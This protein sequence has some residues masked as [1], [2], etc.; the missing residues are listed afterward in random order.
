MVSGNDPL[1]SLLN[2]FQVVK[3]ALS[4]LESGVKKATKDFGFSWLGLKSRRHNTEPLGEFNNPGNAGINVKN[5]K[6]HISVSKKKKKPSPPSDEGRRKG[7]SI[8]LPDENYLG[9]SCQ[10]LAQ[11]IPQLS[12]DVKQKGEKVTNGPSPDS[13]SCTHLDHWK[14]ITN[15]LEGKKADVNIILGNLNF[16]KVGGMVSTLVGVTSQVK[17]AV[18]SPEVDHLRNWL[19]LLSLYLGLYAPLYDVPDKKKLFSVQDFFRYTEAEDSSPNFNAILSRSHI[20][21]YTNWGS[22]I[23]QSHG[24]R[25][26]IFEAS[27]LVLIN[28]A[29]NLPEI[30]VQSLAS[31]CSTLLGTAT[32]ISCE[33]LKQRLQ[34]GLFETVGEA[35][36][37]TWQQDVLKLAWGFMLSPRSLLTAQHPLHRELD[38]WETIAVGALSGGIAAVVTIRFDVLKA[39][40]MTA[41]H[42]QPISTS[43]VVLS[44][45]H[46]RDYELAKKAMTNSE[47]APGDEIPEKKN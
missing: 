42:G 31:F 5:S 12:K 20:T 23:V 47:E 17:E 9:S 34:A 43:I 11:N 32:R 28:V 39:R 18:K 35:I 44:I 10:T 33:V 46:Q 30:Q 38:P 29:P 2:S 15:L 24:L 19:N 37:G 40:M 21:S 3:D 25:T 22:G 45:L 41:P 6:N 8:K 27:K 1:E 26:G 4:P 13:L 7:L 14:A 36:V 16:A